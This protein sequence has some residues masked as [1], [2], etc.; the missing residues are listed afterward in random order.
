ME[1]NKACTFILPLFNVYPIFGNNKTRRRIL[2]SNDMTRNVAS[3]MN[4]YDALKGFL[5]MPAL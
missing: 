5:M 3:T 1:K 4:D 2:G